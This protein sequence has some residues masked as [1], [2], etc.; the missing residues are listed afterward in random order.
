MVVFLKRYWCMVHLSVENS[1]LVVLLSC[2]HGRTIIL[3]MVRKLMMLN[4]LILRVCAFTKKNVRLYL[5]CSLLQMQ[6]SKNFGW[7]INGDINFNWKTLLEH[8]VRPY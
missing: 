1:R 6:D 2:Y 8:K 5:N 7:E 3:Q 4:T